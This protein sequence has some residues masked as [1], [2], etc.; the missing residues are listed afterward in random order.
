MKIKI[1]KI[2]DIIIIPTISYNHLLKT[3]HLP[4]LKRSICLSW[5]KSV[6]DWS[7]KLNN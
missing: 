1:V 4:F 3:I 6:I 5:D 7:E 2:N